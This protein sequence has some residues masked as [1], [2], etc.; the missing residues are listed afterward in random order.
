MKRGKK[1]SFLRLSTWY[2]SINNSKTQDCPSTGKWLLYFNYWVFLFF[3]IFS[4]KQIS[5]FILF[6]FK[7]SYVRSIPKELPKE[8]SIIPDTRYTSYYYISFPQHSSV[9]EKIKS[10][11]NASV[12]SKRLCQFKI[13]RVEVIKD[14]SQM[15]SKDQ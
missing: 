1:V 13:R 5:I 6:Q 15:C 7:T 3:I 8:F 11:N 14:G 12:R 4:Y 9:Q 10:E 2:Q